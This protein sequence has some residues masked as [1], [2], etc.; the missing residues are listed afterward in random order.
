MERLLSLTK[1]TIGKCKMLNKASQSDL[2][3][4]SSFLQKH[5]KSSQFTPAVAGGVSFLRINVGSV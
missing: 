3:K 5:A 4:Q 2:R 1:L